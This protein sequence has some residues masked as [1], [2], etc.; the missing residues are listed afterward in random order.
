MG[1]VKEWAQGLLE[2]IKN[3][4]KEL[5]EALSSNKNKE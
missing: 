1:V 3:Q 5:F 2:V 4:N